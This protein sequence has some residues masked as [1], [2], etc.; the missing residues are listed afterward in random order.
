MGDRWSI[1]ILRDAHRGLKRFSEFQAGLGI[2]PNILSQRLAHLCKAGLMM[3]RPYTSHPP[4]LEYL[5][6]SRGRSFGPVLDALLRWGDEHSHC[7][8]PAIRGVPG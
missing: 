4:R 2:A 1:L 7:R 3:R 6:T 8:R 5:L